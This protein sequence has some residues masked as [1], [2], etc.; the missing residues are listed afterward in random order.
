[1]SIALHGTGKQAD[2]TGEIPSPNQEDECHYFTADK[3]SF[4]H[5]PLIPGTTFFKIRNRSMIAL[6]LDMR[7]NSDFLRCLKT[8]IGIRRLRTR[9]P[10][11]GVILI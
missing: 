9:L 3:S 2:Y 5:N 11:E 8:R 4:G 6:S 10:F 7:T 1:M